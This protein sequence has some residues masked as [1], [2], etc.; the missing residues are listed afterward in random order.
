MAQVCCHAGKSHITASVT[1][2]A[3]YGS[4]G[5]VVSAHWQRLLF[6]CV[7]IPL[8]HAIRIALQWHVII[9]RNHWALGV[10]A[11][12]CCFRECSYLA[13]YLCKVYVHVYGYAISQMH[14]YF[15][16][17]T[18]MLVFMGVNASTHIHAYKHKHVYICM[19]TKSVCMAFYAK[20]LRFK[21]HCMQR[22]SGTG[23]SSPS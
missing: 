3:L 16:M 17:H 1:V 22:G 11:N 13:S 23:G 5:L 9:K 7:L 6:V 21:R 18:R 12:V 14:I 19:Q 10:G 8:S 15:H 2:I 4:R 20:R